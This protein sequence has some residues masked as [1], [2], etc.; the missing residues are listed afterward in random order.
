M[1]DYI[2]NLMIVD[3]ER[4]DQMR[5][6]YRAMMVLDIIL[7]EYSCHYH[8]EKNRYGPD[9]Y[10]FPK[11]MLANFLEDPTPSNIRIPFV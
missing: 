10:D 11:Y 5:T 4:Y 8:V 9:R 7:I 1:K 6:D 2:K 3:R